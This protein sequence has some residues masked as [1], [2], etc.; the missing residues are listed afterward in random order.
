[1]HNY[2]VE[3][4]HAAGATNL[5]EEDEGIAFCVNF[6]PDPIR[7]HALARLRIKYAS[8]VY[9][10]IKERFKDIS[11]AELDMALDETFDKLSAYALKTKLRP[12]NGTLSG[13]VVLQSTWVGKKFDRRDQRRRRLLCETFIN[14]WQI[15]KDANEPHRSDTITEKD[16]EELIIAIRRALDPKVYAN[17]RMVLEAIAS[18]YL[19]TNGLQ[20]SGLGPNPSAAAISRYLDDCGT[21]LPVEEISRAILVLQYRVIGVL[22]E[23]GWQVRDLLPKK[24]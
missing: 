23:N 19:S 7:G 9:D 21:P 15:Y 11:A 12:V 17:T 22:E 8:I 18:L 2:F 16:L 5:R 24:A 1:M 3:I 4:A 10:Y 20:V 14:T 6:L 13:L